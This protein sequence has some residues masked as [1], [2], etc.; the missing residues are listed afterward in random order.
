[1]VNP[2]AQIPTWSLHFLPN[3]DA[4]E[5]R[6]F[7]PL[8]LVVPLDRCLDAVRLAEFHS[9]VA[10]RE[11]RRNIALRGHELQERQRLAPLGHDAPAFGDCQNRG[12]ANTDLAEMGRSPRW[13]RLYVFGHLSLVGR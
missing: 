9:V 11:P 5:H 13:L 8:V 7:E 10:I 3:I 4:P 6:L 1:M 2:F 12:Q